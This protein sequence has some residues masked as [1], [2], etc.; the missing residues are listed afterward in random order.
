MSLWQE[1]EENRKIIGEGRISAMDQ[2]IKDCGK[3]GHHI[4]YHDIVYKQ[5]EYELFS[6]WF[7]DAIRPFRIMKHDDDKYS[8]I[9]SQ[10]DFEYDWLNE[11]KNKSVYGDGY[12][13]EKVFKKCIEE[14][15]IHLVPTIMY[16]SESGMFCLYCKSNNDAEEISYHLSSLYK[17]EEKMIKRIKEVK[18][19]NLNDKNDVRI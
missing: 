15:L 19:I 3:K 16:D 17:D 1:Y 4:M 10:E 9:L 8:V 12:D 11:I 7:E 13:Y 14:E 2:Y 6:S 5:E 18:E